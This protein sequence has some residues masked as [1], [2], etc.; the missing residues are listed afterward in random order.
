MPPQLPLPSATGAPAVTEAG[1]HMQL[2][3]ADPAADTPAHLLVGPGASTVDIEGSGV[4]GCG[5]WALQIADVL[6]GPAL[7]Y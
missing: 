1:Q 4:Q 2:F 5:V 6:Q 3:S 7:S